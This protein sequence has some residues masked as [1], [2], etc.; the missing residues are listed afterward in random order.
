M[1]LYKALTISEGKNELFE[2]GFET[3]ADKSVKIHTQRY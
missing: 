3:I 1:L 2:G